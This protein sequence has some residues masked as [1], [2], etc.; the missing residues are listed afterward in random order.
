MLE[1]LSQLDEINPSDDTNVIAATNRMVILH[2]DLLRPADWRGRLSCRSPMRRL[3]HK[4]CRSTPKRGT[5]IK[6]STAR[7][8]PVAPTTLTDPSAKRSASTPA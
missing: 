1:L 8:F 3:G 6:T 4:S 2:Q 5:T 7:N